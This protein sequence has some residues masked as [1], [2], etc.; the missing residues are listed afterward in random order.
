MDAEG[1]A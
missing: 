1:N